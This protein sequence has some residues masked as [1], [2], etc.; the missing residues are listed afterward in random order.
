MTLSKQIAKQIREVLLDG[1]WVA[2]NYKTQLSGLGWEQATVKVENLNT[3]AALAFHIDYYIAGLIRVFQGGPLDIKDKYS[4]DAPPITS[5]QDWEKRLQHLFDDAETFANL[6]E[7]MSEEALMAPFV[8]EKYGNN[9]INIQAL[10]E[11]CYYHLGQI[12]LIKKLLNAN[13]K[14]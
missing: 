5:Q 1:T 13:S 3:I 6:V 9:Y 12:V 10:I 11:H 14:S 8:E 7:Q 2:T 4:Y